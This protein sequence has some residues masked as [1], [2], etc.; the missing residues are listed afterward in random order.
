MQPQQCHIIS[1][2]KTAGILRMFHLAKIDANML[3]N[4]FAGEVLSL[5]VYLYY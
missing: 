1:I 5:P 3:F 2:S 4:L